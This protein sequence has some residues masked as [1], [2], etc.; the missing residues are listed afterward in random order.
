MDQTYKTTQATKSLYEQAIPPSALSTYQTITD[1]IHVARSLQIHYLWIDALC[2]VQDDPA[3]VTRELA[4]MRSIYAGAYLTLT[5]G[6][7]T[8]S[9]DPFL[10]SAIPAAEHPDI[11]MRFLCQDGTEGS[12]LLQ[13]QQNFVSE[14]ADDP[15][16]ARGWTLQEDLLSPRVLHFGPY[17]VL[18][19]CATMIAT[20]RSGGEPRY[21]Q[22]ADRQSLDVASLQQLS[23]Q[24]LM[25]RWIEIVQDYAR[26]R[27]S[28]P[29]DKLPALAGIADLFDQ[30]S[31][32]SSPSSSSPRYLA[33]VWVADLHAQLLWYVDAPLPRPQRYRAPSWSWAATEGLVSFSGRYPVHV[34]SRLELVD[35]AV[36]LEAEE[37][38]FGVVS[39]AV[40]RAE[41][42][43][44]KIGWSQSWRGLDSGFFFRFR[45]EWED[46]GDT[47]N[48]TNL[49]PDSAED[50]ELLERGTPEI[51]V[52]EVTTEI[53][54]SPSGPIVC[55]S[56]GLALVLAG[57][58]F[59]RIGRFKHSRVVK[60]PE[61]MEQNQAVDYYSEDYNG[62]TAFWVN[63][64]GDEE[65]HYWTEE[66]IK[67]VPWEDEDW[68][69]DC[70]TKVLKLI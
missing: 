33:G 6:C 52:L 53:S 66:D 3:D 35:C 41:G 56:H 69:R 12:L 29:A 70:E 47:L 40:M 42:R 45:P 8:S 51:W 48:D 43:V 38:P 58:C 10:A 9:R 32:S 46:P 15:I 28:V 16:A 37:L 25:A 1:A 68:F 22:P 63:E 44:R 5:A 39:S 34:V 60:T 49:I 7:T 4:K 13:S 31:P 17:S 67:E 21:L 11:Q 65:G 50:K 62:P 2:I 55:L 23:P 30:V 14:R 36:A 20:D 24:T 59:R 61:Y 27:L 19:R 54:D 64:D 57:D 18:W 26:R